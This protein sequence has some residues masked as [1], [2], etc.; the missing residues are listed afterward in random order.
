VNFVVT[1]WYTHLHQV[2]YQPFGVTAWWEAKLENFADGN[3]KDADCFHKALSLQK[4]YG[5]PEERGISPKAEFIDRQWPVDLE[6]APY[7]PQPV[8]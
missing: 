7:Y 4:S 3:W 8:W 6:H 5:T 1:F 2:E